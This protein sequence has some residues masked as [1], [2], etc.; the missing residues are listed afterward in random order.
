MTN[1]KSEQRHPLRQLVKHF[2]LTGEGKK[3]KVSLKEQRME[4]ILQ[5]L[6]DE[7]VEFINDGQDAAVGLAAQMFE[8]EHV[9]KLVSAYFRL[10]HSLTGP[11]LAQHLTIKMVEKSR[12][13]MKQGLETTTSN[14]GRR[15]LIDAEAYSCVQEAFYE[16]C[17]MY[18]RTP[19]GQLLMTH[20]KKLMAQRG[21]PKS[22]RDLLTR[23]RA[24]ELAELIRRTYQH[25]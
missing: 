21:I 16:L 19:G 24:S 2:Y 9:L 1:K 17:Y 11:L 6:L 22:Q 3:E 5:G 15:K 4:E 14:L 20:A 13:L 8:Y 23:H 7:G 10:D 18:E 25:Y 12:D